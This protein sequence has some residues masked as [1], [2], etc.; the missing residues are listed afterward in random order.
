MARVERSITINAPVEKVFAYM[1]DPM[2]EPEWLP[3]AVEVKDVT[4][5]EEG[6]GSHYRSV[7]K[8]LGLLF[9]SETTTLEYIPNQR[10]VTQSKGGIVSTWTYTFE[11]HD[12]GTKANVVVEFTVPIPVLGKVAEAL[13]LK[14]IEREADLAVANVKAIM[15]G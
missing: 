14:Q 1:A 12:G 2:S 15:E 9:E 10:I 11:P 13:A 8:L 6:V 3:G 4:L 5:T 7:Y